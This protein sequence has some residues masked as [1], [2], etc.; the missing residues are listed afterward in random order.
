MTMK[1]DYIQLMQQRPDLFTNVDEEN[2]VN[3]ITDREQ[4]AK[5]EAQTGKETGIIYSDEYIMLLRDAVIFPDNSVGTYIRII[6]AVEKGAVVVLIL[7]RK[8][9]LLL[10]HFRHS[11]RRFSWEIPRGFGEKWLSSEQN[12][13][14]E[15]FEETGMKNIALFYLGTV[16]AD[17]GLSAGLADIYIAETDED[18]RFVNNDDR[19]GIADYR[20]VTAEQFAEMALCGEICDGYSLSAVA[21]AQFKGKL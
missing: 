13:A 1:N 7:C 21:F 15:I 20:L 11:L 5:V 18:V 9:I 19:E 12:A 2:A 6:S 16:C 3:I 14:K 17:T 4:I 10:Q 8:R